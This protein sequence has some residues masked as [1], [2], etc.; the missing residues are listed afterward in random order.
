MKPKLII[1]I[2]GLGFDLISKENTPFLYAFGKKGSIS[3]LETLFA[4][5]GIEYCFFT[6]KNPDETN[7]WLEFSKEEHSIFNSPLMSIFGFGK[8]KSYIG[9]LLQLANKRTWMSG[10]YGIPK[11]DLKYFDTSAKEGLWKLDYFKGKKFSF[12]K[13]PFFVTEEKKKLVF[14]YENDE[15]RLKRIL[16]E[17]EKEVYY[18]QLMKIDKTLH[19]FGKGSKEIK[20]ALKGMD[21]LLQKYVNSFILK[22][23]EAEIILWG[24]HSLANVKNYINIEKMLPKSREYLR[25]IEGTTACFWFKNEEIKKKVLDSIKGEKKIKVL[26]PQ[27]AKKYKIPLS[28]KY[29]ELVLYLEKGDYFF[30]N[31]YQKNVG[32][33]FFAMHGYP[34]DK[35][36]NGVVISNKKTPQR[37][38]MNEMIKY[39]T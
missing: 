35:E 24:D 31:Y 26:T 20:N 27:S 37:I 34:D 16:S 18:V 22:N 8:L 14:R 25:F 12:Y 30:P 32:E 29:G 23:P 38:K 21:L 9:A 19:K 36:M 7:L 17:K 39:L 10:L 3:E 5:T 13:W 33:K 11:E 4:F 15:A 28:K 2:D 6:G 1:C